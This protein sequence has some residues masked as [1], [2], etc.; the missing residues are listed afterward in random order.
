M[1]NYLLHIDKNIRDSLFKLEKNSE[2]CLVVI[3]EAE[4]FLGTLS[5][6]DVRK[7]ILNGVKIESSI[8][9]IFN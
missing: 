9:S 7:A 3:N 1:K 8:Q 5:D 6:G 4:M 2:K